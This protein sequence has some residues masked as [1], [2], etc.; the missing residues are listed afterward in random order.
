MVFYLIKLR[1]IE[2]PLNFIIILVY[3]TL[4]LVVNICVLILA[5]SQ[6]MQHT[7]TNVQGKPKL[8]HLGHQYDYKHIL[9]RSN[10]DLCSKWNAV[11]IQG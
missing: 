11:S 10:M 3:E 2:D 7:D 5:I 6:A 9:R 1:P 4:A 8:H